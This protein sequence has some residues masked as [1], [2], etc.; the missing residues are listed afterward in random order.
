[1]VKILLRLRTVQQV[2][3][4]FLS[5]QVQVNISILQTE[6]QPLPSICFPVH[7]SWSA[8]YFFPSAIYEYG[9]GSRLTWTFYQKILMSE[10]PNHHFSKYCSTLKLF[11]VFMTRQCICA[12]TRKWDKV[13]GHVV[14]VGDVRN[15]YSFSLKAE[16]GKRSLRTPRCK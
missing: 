13:G 4:A 5:L 3:V 11:F 6:L 8:L 2:S 10:S 14:C 9:G 1:M 16:E 7:H 12:L 15:A